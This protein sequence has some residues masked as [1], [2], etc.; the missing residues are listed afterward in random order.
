[1][2]SATESSSA[3][4][5]NGT[6]PQHNHLKEQEAKIVADDPF[7]PSRFQNGYPEVDL[8]SS[9][10]LEVKG[11]SHLPSPSAS[12]QSFSP[13]L[14]ATDSS[15]EY[16]APSATLHERKYSGSFE[17]FLTSSLKRQ[18]NEKDD[19]PTFSPLPISKNL[20]PHEL[21]AIPEEKLK[22]PRKLSISKNGDSQKLT[23][24]EL[25]EL[26]SAPESLPVAS[27]T[28]SAVSGS[29]SLAVSPVSAEKPRISESLRPESDDPRSRRRAESFRDL[30]Q[31][32]EGRVLLSDQ[33]PTNTL[34]E[35][36]RFSSRTSSS[37]NTARTPSYIKTS[38]R[39]QSP[40]RKPLPSGIEPLDLNQISNQDFNG[41]MKTPQPEHPPSPIPQ[42][43]PLPPMSIPT[44]LQLELSSSRPSPLYIYRSHASENQYESSKIKFERLLNFLLLPP[45][46]EKVLYFGSLACLDAWLYTFTILPLRFFKALAVLV[47]WWGLVIA[48]EAQFI[49][50]FIYHGSGR[51]WHRKRGRSVSMESTTRS[52]SVSRV[53]RAAMSTTTSYQP[54]PMR[55]PEVL[56]G[57]SE[58][59][60]LDTDRKPR[61]GWGRKHRRRKSQPSSLSSYHKADLLQGA[62]I[63][64]SC[65]ILLKL[66]ASRMY[67]GIRGQSA[68]KLYVIYNLLE[69]CSPVIVSS[70]ANKARYVIDYSLLLA[71]IYLNVCSQ[72]KH[73]KEI[74]MVEVNSSGHLGCSS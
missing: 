48:K 19:Q 54:P 69:V 21:H 14:T 73:S 70:K 40:R 35:R 1:M 16:T 27:P 45:Q 60:K 44:Y 15:S 23:G 52:R 11:P 53:S 39:Q 47:K 3:S 46:L 25:Q 63:I 49:G 33:T 67:H 32:T 26:T 58:N 29:T 50:S 42:S 2:V 17:K 36:P 57:V 7:D 64:C 20:P 4:T 65:I 8:K 38:S 74:H 18:E 51:M 10:S 56:N 55:V 9:V 6:M 62:V 12:P 43:I 72:T 30:N 24:V 71:K 41:T 31:T 13:S 22:K 66:D 5:E 28:R 34:R 61:P 59:L 68:I 37:H